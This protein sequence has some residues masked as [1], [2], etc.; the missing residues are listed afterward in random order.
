MIP[1]AWFGIESCLAAAGYRLLRKPSSPARNASLWLL[2]ANIVGIGSWS[3]L[4]FGHRNLPVSTIASA[5]L[6]AGGVLYVAKANE[7][8]QTAAAEG[9][10]LVAWVAFATVLTAAIWRR[11]R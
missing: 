8:D 1:V 9:L 6:L 11:N 3:R 4:F 10:P 2:A 5:A 7:V